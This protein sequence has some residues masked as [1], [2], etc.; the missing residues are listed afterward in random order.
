MNACDE[1]APAVAS[2]CDE[3]TRACASSPVPPSRAECRVVVSGLL[4]KG[5]ERMLDCAKKH[6]FDRGILGCETASGKP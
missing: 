4:D 1:S 3:L 6:C 2:A 5:R